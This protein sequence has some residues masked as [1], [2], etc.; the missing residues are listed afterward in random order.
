VLNDALADDAVR[1]R[2]INEGAEPEPGTPAEQAAVIDHEETKW[3]KVIQSAH[4]KPE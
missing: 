3:A 1:K 4:L 2:I